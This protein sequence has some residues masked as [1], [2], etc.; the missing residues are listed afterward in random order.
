MSNFRKFHITDLP[1]DRLFFLLKEDFHRNLFKFISEYNFSDL[2]SRFFNGKLNIHTFRQWK[3]RKH[4]IPLW[5]LVK[6]NQE[7]GQQLS[8]NEIESNIEAY[9]GPSTSAIIKNPKFPIVEDHRLMKL[10]GH[11]LGDGHINGAFGTNLPKGKSHSE[12]RNFSNELL[13]SFNYDLQLF[14]EVPTST[15]YNHGHVIVPNSIG[16][17]LKHIYKI[18]FGTFGS[19]LPKEI[20]KLDKK[21]IKG[22]LRS[23]GDDEAHVF[24]SSIEFY[25]ANRKLINDIF[26]L[27]RIKYPGLKLSNIKINDSGK[28]PKYSFSI[29]SESLEDYHNSIGFDCPKKREDLLF[30]V[31]RIKNY[32][33]F[34]T[35]KDT[36]NIILNLLNKEHSAKELSRSFLFDILT[37]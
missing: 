34:R 36:P 13:D 15:D 25:S 14:R 32:K 17:I 3:Y 24:D 28:N 23:F 2:N 21:V 33:K 19:E 35:N 11:F 27:T 31:N 10:I 1:E 8:L 7:F 30:N 16:Y 5:F 26:S 9:K 4:F 37:S 18:S 29:L 6:L 20:F 22:F 12:Y